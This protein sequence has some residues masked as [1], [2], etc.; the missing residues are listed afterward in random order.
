MSLRDEIVAEV[1]AVYDEIRPDLF[2]DATCYLIKREGISANFEV[3]LAIPDRWWV[4]FNKFRFAFDRV[5]D[6]FR[7]ARIDDEFRDALTQA[8]HIAL[9]SAVYAIDPARR[10]TDV[11][12]P[13]GTKPW[14]FV[15]SNL[16]KDL[17]FIYE[18]EPEPEP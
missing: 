8:S 11:L 13:E 17:A 6:E 4:K 9:R 7:F 3:V 1:G 2:P 16:D 10:S 14:W 5:Q 15:Y 18:P 12:E